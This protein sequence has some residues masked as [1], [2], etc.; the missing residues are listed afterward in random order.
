MNST[1]VPDS[2]VPIVAY[3]LNSNSPSMSKKT[4]VRGASFTP[5]EDISIA[6]S[7]INVSENAII[8]TE[9]KGNEF[10]EAIKA[11]YNDKHKPGN[12]ENRSCQSLKARCK[13]LHKECMIF[14]GCY[15]RLVRQS[16]TGVSPNDLIRISTGVFNGI[17]MCQVTDNCRL[18]FR[19][20]N[21][22]EVLKSHD[23]YVY[24][25]Q[26]VLD[27]AR[28]D[29]S[30][31]TSKEEQNENSSDDTIDSSD[32]R[33]KDPK[34]PIGRKRAKDQL[35]KGEETKKAVTCS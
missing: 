18:P 5:A 26:N 1:P 34:R 2:A 20:L 30:S 28:G 31:K 6:K 9:Q 10:Y 13:S 23:K 29:G 8:G 27:G 22:W 32:C 7:W 14:N 4:P 19:Y 35:R 33:L 17:D 16:P 21:A 3:A 25:Y 12:R 15:A 24:A 11:V